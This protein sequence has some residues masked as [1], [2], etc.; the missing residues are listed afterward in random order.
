MDFQAEKQL[1]LEY[2]ELLDTDPEA[3]MLRF[4]APN[5]IW[6]GFHPFDVIRKPKAVAER[7]WLPLANAL[8]RIQRRMD[9]FF[10]GENSLDAA[11]G[12]WVVSMG[13]LAGLLDEPWLGIPPTSRMAFLRYAA[14]HR[15]EAGRIT[16]EAMFFDVPHLMIQAGLAPFPQQTAAHLVQ[17]GPMTHDGL[18]IKQQCAAETARTLSAINAM[19]ADLGQWQLGIP[20]EDELRRSWNDDMV[21]WGPAGIGATCT[22]ERYARQHAGPFRAAFS[23]RSETNHI[24]RL[25][26]GHYGG[27]FGWPNF[28]AV[29]SGDFMGMPATGKAGEFRVID[30]YRRAGDNLAENWV[31]IDFL[32]FWSQQG[33]DIMAIAC[34][35]TIGARRHRQSR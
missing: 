3:A 7:F 12:R 1:V 17:P 29:L 30:I 15:V 20:L 6:R 10:A 25:A 33:V 11:G 26:E 24:C 21:W 5:L 4:C 2:Y 28:K 35:A 16:E 27:F 8:R 13:H 32:H 14:F 23:E 22:I 9:V 34:S 31:F 19:I 18:L